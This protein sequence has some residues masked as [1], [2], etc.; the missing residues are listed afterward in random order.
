M[1]TIRVQRQLTRC[2]FLKFLNNLS[3]DPLLKTLG[4]NFRSYISRDFHQFKR[5]FAEFKRSQHE[6]CVKIPLLIG[7]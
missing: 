3:D 2:T 1:R 4:P 5:L 7:L 6:V